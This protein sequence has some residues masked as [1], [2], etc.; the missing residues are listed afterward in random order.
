MKLIENIINL[1]FQATM[2][3][4]MELGRVG[5]RFSKYGNLLFNTHHTL[6]CLFSMVV[7]LNELTTISKIN[8]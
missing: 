8:Y 2:N 4:N 6:K 7:F 1:K 5:N 3:V